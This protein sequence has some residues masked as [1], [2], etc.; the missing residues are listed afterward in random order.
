MALAWKAG[1]VNSPRGFESRILRQ[2]SLEAT[3]V[4]ISGFRGGLT[5]DLLRHDDD[6]LGVGEAPAWEQHLVDAADDHQAR[7][8]GGAE[9]LL[10]D[11]AV[12][13][14]DHLAGD[15]VGVGL[16][17]LGHRDQV[18]LRGLLEAEQWPGT[19]APARHVSTDDDT[20][21]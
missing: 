2:S 21:D 18:P 1:W 14:E 3:P 6:V 19:V 11:L 5:A 8:P 13:A 20:A 4:S 17:G 7:L 10:W 16:A 15:L 12:A 9:V